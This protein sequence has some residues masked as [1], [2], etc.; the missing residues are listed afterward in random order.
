MTVARCGLQFALKIMCDR[1]CDP[2]LWIRSPH[3]EQAALNCRHLM[4]APYKR[5][6]LAWKC[7]GRRIRARRRV[8]S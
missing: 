4:L 6:E 8:L 5:R 1:E 3:D 7:D 2:L